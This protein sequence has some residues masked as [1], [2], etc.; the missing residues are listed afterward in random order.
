MFDAGFLH[1]LSQ[2][3]GEPGILGRHEELE[4]A[5]H[6]GGAH[7]LLEA[8]GSQRA[9]LELGH[10]GVVDRQQG[11]HGLDANAVQVEVVCDG[12]QRHLGFLLE[13]L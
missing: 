4:E 8:D 12:G 9:A 2:A 5:L 10:Q 6:L 11:G 7:A 1:R 13:D 3:L